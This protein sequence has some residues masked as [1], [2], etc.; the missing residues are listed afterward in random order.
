MTI[1]V[2]LVNCGNHAD[3]MIVVTGGAADRLPLKRGES[4]ELRPDIDYRFGEVEHGGDETCR[5]HHAMA[6]MAEGPG[7]R[8]VRSAFNPSGSGKVD[9]I[10]ALA[11]ALINEIDALPDN[12]P[13]VKAVAK[14]EVEG[15]AQWAV[16]AA[17]APD[18]A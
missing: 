9:R 7:D 12:D 10:K 18:S 14:T 13:R 1:A 8:I 2:A 11:A 16:K 15:A 17:T 4:I 6:V 5:Q 3:D